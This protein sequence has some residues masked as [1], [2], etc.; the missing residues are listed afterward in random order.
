[1]D[2]LILKVGLSYGRGLL[3]VTVSLVLIG[4][5]RDEWADEMFMGCR[6]HVSIRSIAYEFL[7]HNPIYRVELSDSRSHVRVR[8]LFTDE[9]IDLDGTF[10][11]AP[12]NPGSSSNDY[13][14][15]LNS[16]FT[17]TEMIDD[18]FIIDGEMER[19]FNIHV[20]DRW[21]FH[22]FFDAFGDE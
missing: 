7:G 15:F 16:V 21:Y 18:R 5:G 22:C 19:R 3:L 20:G 13:T 11:L 2:S 10:R 17:V 9:I 4:C 8:N 12:F 6:P 1:M 14:E